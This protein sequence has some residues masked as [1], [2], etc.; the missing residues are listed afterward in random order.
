MIEAHGGVMAQ[1]QVAD[2]ADCVANNPNMGGSEYMRAIIFEAP[3]KL[4]LADDIPMPEPADGELLVQ[5][6]HAGLCGTNV[7]PYLG[8]G[9]W[10]EIDWPPPPGFHG[11]ENVGVIVESRLDGWKPGTLVLAQPKTYDG[12]VEYYVPNPATMTHLSADDGD[13]GRFLLAQPLSTVM[14][15]VTRTGPLIGERCAVL[16]QGPIGLM[17]TY[18]I[19][20]IGARQVIAIDL[21]PWRL[22][23]A[24]R[25]G[26]TDVVDASSEDVL[27]AVRELT[28][29]AMVDLCVEAAG[30]AA[31]LCTAALLPRRRGRLTVFGVPRH[32]CQTFPWF[33]ATENETQIITS[34]GGNWTDY[35]SLAV[36][37]LASDW[38]ELTDIVTPRLPWK[39][40]ADAFEM[41][42][43]PAQ[44]SGALKI[45]LEL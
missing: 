2:A 36:E 35:Q 41:S 11:H 40:A 24:R 44:H 10:A 6:T 37:K 34:R 4:R 20:R 31:G 38:A 45:V 18:L 42:A 16:G 39:Q 26:A 28:G 43:F 17:F 15:A 25:L 14:R 3:R 30:T 9:H 33:H 8:V 32:D 22:E 1:L 29:G 13:V 23:W 7:A 19:R 21:V 12:F 5:C 27:E